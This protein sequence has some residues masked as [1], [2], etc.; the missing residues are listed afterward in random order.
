VSILS[1]SI[2]S[3][4]ASISHLVCAVFYS[5]VR[6]DRLYCTFPHYFINSRNL[7]TKLFNLKCVSR[8]SLQLFS[9]TF[10]VLRIIQRNITKRHRSARTVRLVLWDFPTNLNFLN[11]PF[12]KPSNIKFYKNPSHSSRPV[13]CRQTDR[14]THKYDKV[15]SRF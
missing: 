14:R 1:S 10:L 9:E 12:G 4:T 2:I 15:N 7:R 8:F 11:G 5:H 3:H 6:P 13:P